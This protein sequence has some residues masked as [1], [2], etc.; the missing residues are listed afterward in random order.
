MARPLRVDFE[1]AVHHVLNRG[2]AQTSIFRSTEDRRRFIRH[3][4]EIDDRYGVE[5]HALV[6]LANHYHLLVRSSAGRLSEAV[7]WLDG[8][9]VK[10]FN[11]RHG[12]TGG[13][14]QGRFTSRLVDTDAYLETVAHYI[15]LNPVEAGVVDDALS[16]RWSSL[17]SYAGSVRSVPWLRTDLVLAGRSPAEF[18]EATR[19][20]GR[21]QLTMNHTVEPV[22]ADP[23][24]ATLSRLRT[25]ETHIATALGVSVDELYVPTSGRPNPARLLAIGLTSKVHGVTDEQIA[26]RYGLR[27]RSGVRQAR[28]RLRHQLATDERMADLAR[29][30]N[31]A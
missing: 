23:E 31:A 21:L 19:S 10:A 5:V 9:Y 16:H 30:L 2:T 3:L 11:R 17:P 14:F 27:S 4:S 25:V 8:T 26:D 7:Q 15:H 1:G 13:L 22:L 18:L 6:L 24:S 29:R 28:R 12:R 20:A